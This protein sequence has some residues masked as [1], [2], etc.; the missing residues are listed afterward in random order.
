MQKVT[1]KLRSSI[2]FFLALN[3]LSVLL[4]PNKFKAYPIIALFLLSIRFYLK[5]K[6]INNNS[7][8]IY[9]LT[10]SA[11]FF[12]FLVSLSYSSNL[13]LGLSRLSTMLPI[14]IL[15]LIF[16]LLKKGDF[17]INEKFSKT[18][19]YGFVF[20]NVFFFIISFLF[21]WNLE[22]NFNETI[23]HYSNLINIRFGLFAQHPIYYSI[24]LGISILFLIELTLNEVSKK[25]KFLN[26]LLGLILVL[27]L[28]VLM[29]KGPIIYLLLAISAYSFYKLN[30][31]K[32]LILI[33]GVTIVTII[34]IQFLPKYKNF[35]RFEEL[36][37]TTKYE[38]NSSSTFIRYNIYK[39]S[40]QK[41][42]ESPLLGYGVGT[43]QEVLD[44][45]YTNSGIDLSIKTYNS[46]N[47]YFSF[48]L[49]AG[50]IALLIFLYCTILN[51]SFLVK[52][53]AFLGFS[54][55]IFILLNF[56]TEN[57]IE[58]ENGAIVYGF[59][60]SF[61]IFKNLHKN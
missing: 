12:L 25:L 9:F 61:F 46:H 39:C 55:L 33:A 51:I 29:R 8:L 43:T 6:K 10:I 5:N 56:L 50:I 16:F 58:R 2:N 18:L 41:I 14:I 17:Y 57:V 19:M 27:V 38:N 7:F 20:A 30:F 48:C 4:V 21:F 42:K 44:P 40:L 11:P 24:Y 1:S 53:K 26:I 23:V 32:Y 34:S 36:I 54:V 22:F 52:K 49:T 31:I 3:L 13:K 15:P 37:S 35:N 59:L 60:I 28:G 45:C 47:Q